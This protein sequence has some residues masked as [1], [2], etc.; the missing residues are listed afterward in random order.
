VTINGLRQRFV[1][2]KNDRKKPGTSQ[3]DYVL[4]SADAPEVDTYR[5]PAPRTAV[6]TARI[7]GSSDV[8]RLTSDLAED[9]RPAWSPDGRRWEAWVARGYRRTPL[10]MTR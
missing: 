7:V 1:V 4:L 3:P 2:L 6:T 10:R 9:A 5:A 8:R